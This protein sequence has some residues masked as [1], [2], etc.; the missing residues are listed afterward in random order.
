[1]S[2]RPKHFAVWT[3]IPV[4]DMERAVDY[5]ETVLQTKLERQNGETSSEAVFKTED[6]SGVSC[7]LSLGQP[8]GN[9]NG[10][11]IHLS[12]PGTLEE[13]LERVKTAG[14]KVVSDITTIDCGRFFYSHDLDGNSIGFYAP[15]NATS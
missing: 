4:S 15:T 13:T 1:M 5:Y 11:T 2:F 10:P 14:G 8:A 7:H 12:C 9:G 3:E 6:E